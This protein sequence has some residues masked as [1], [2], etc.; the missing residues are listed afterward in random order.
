MLLLTQCAQPNEGGMIYGVDPT[1]Q[2]YY[3]SFN[4]YYN[5]NTSVPIGFAAQTK[6]VVGECRIYDDGYRQIEIDPTYWSQTDDAG[7]M[8]L[9]LHELGHCVF[10]RTHNRE[11]TYDS[12]GDECPFSIMDPYIF[13]NPC[14]TNLQGH[15]ME[16]LPYSEPGDYL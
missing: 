16:E 12:N 14:Y 1:F 3:D 13:G 5:L 8:T 15:Y 7:K 6:P 11:D 4:A 10:N 9:V 2:P